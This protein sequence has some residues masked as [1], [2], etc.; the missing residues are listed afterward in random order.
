MDMC[1]HFFLIMEY[2]I[3]VFALLK[4]VTTNYYRE[5]AFTYYNTSFLNIYELEH[6]ENIFSFVA[7][8][9]MRTSYN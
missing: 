3:P 7:A 5:C 6:K 2:N 4:R 9:V 1:I 8:Q